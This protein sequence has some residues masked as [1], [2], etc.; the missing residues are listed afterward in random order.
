MA[1]HIPTV[2][3]ILDA[4]IVLL[5]KTPYE[6]RL[7]GVVP[8]LRVRED[9][10]FRIVFEGQPQDDYLGVWGA[11]DLPITCGDLVRARLSDSLTVSASLEMHKLATMY[12][13]LW[14]ESNK[15]R[16]TYPLK[17]FG[18][19]SKKLGSWGNV[20]FSNTAAKDLLEKCPEIFSDPTGGVTSYLTLRE[21]PDG[22][23][24]VILCD[25]SFRIAVWTPIT[26]SYA[27]REE[28]D[29]G[30]W[31]T[32]LY[33]EKFGYLFNPYYSE[34]VALAEMAIRDRVPNDKKS[35]IAV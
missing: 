27:S 10:N 6:T 7:A 25:M 1:Y 13:S 3:Q 16:P 5:A 18:C 11:T 12:K 29:R 28:V 19:K 9:D 34:E 21:I 30:I 26:L 35:L 4:L 14:L 24:E 15:G 33:L 20:D 32:G 2:E 23:H 8:A 22:I 17:L 31:V